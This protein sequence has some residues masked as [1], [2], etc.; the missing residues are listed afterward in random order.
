MLLLSGRWEPRQPL[1]L[2]DLLIL[3]QSQ[4]SAVCFLLSFAETPHT[5]SLVCS[6]RHPGGPSAHFWNSFLCT[7]LFVILPCGFQPPQKSRPWSLSAVQRAGVLPLERLLCALLQKASPGG[8]LERL[9]P[10]E[11]SQLCTAWDRGLS[12]HPAGSSH[13]M[14]PSI[15][16][17][18]LS[19]GLCQ[20]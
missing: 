15:P 4:P 12:P 10:C 6:Q 9:T 16:F 14:L 7:I 5:C 20:P 2:C 11:E 13:L 17:S 18:M 1:A 8:A 19:T 3:T